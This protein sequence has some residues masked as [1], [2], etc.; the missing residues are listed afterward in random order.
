MKSL[1]YEYKKYRTRIKTF[2]YKNKN[3]KQSNIM[4]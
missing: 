3:D 2:N 4:R 1:E